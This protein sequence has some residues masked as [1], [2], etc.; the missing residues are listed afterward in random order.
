MRR[1]KMGPFTPKFGRR[2]ASFIGRQDIINE[3]LDGI[4]DLNSPM[5]TTIISGVRGP[6]RPHY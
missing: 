5:R 6:E 1:K 2:P 3:L 4:Y